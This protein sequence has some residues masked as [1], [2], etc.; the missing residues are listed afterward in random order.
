MPS[1]SNPDA[2]Q[3]KREGG[4]EEDT[5]LFTHQGDLSITKVEGGLCVRAT[6]RIRKKIRNPTSKKSSARCKNAAFLMEPEFSS[7]ILNRAGHF[8]QFHGSN[9]RRSGK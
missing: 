7:T 4:V 2:L 1:K 6:S 9:R 5:T 8:G 3:K